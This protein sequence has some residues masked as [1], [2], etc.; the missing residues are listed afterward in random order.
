MLFRIWYHSDGTESVQRL[1]L[2]FL[3]LLKPGDDELSESGLYKELGILTNQKDRWEENVPFV[4]SL[5][6]HESVKIQAKALWLL[7]EMGLAYP[8]SVRDAVPSIASFRNSPVP[9]LRERAL[10]AI[11]RI[12]RGDYRLIEPYWADLFRFADDEEAPVRLSFI[13]ASE[14]IATNTPG[15]YENYMPV[16]EKL[17]HDPDDKVRMEAPEIFRVL[18]KRKPEF[19]RPFTEELQE[20]SETDSNRV[21]RIHCLGAIKATNC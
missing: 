8:Q 7:A 1:T 5:L 21:V 14:N 13:W 15:I 17:L 18:G 16:F 4:S 11:G 20:I 9:L 6:S 3:T 19:V 2:H 12:G 10:N